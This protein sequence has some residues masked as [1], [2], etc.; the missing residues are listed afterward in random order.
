MKKVTCLICAL[1]CFCICLSAC[2]ANTQDDTAVVSAEYEKV[3]LTTQNYG[4]Y[5]AIDVFFSD[6]TYE[7][8]N[9]TY[10]LYCT[11]NVVVSSKGDYSFEGCS[12]VF[13]V[14]QKL[15]ARVSAPFW[16]SDLYTISSASCELDKNGR[17]KTSLSLYGT[18]ATYV[19][20][21]DGGKDN[22]SVGSVT[23]Y[24]LQEKK[25]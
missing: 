15:G 23:G 12:I 20:F 24:A 11:L 7:K 5:L 10:N 9:T 2:S 22:I 8:V 14:G 19:R 21:P 3:K 13:S 16:N 25:K 6:C 4:D 1:L 17:G 18:G